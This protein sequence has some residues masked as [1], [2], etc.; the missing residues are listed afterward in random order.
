M[1]KEAMKISSV[2]GSRTQAFGRTPSERRGRDNAII[3]TAQ[4]AKSLRE[5]YGEANYERI[6]RAAR[7][8]VNKL[9]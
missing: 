2:V 6:N 4:R 1:A 9:F 7:R 3:N 5:R 8:M